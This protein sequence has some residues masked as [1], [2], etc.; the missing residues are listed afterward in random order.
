[1]KCI[2]CN[3]EFKQKNHLSIH[4][5]YHHEGNSIDKE[6]LLIK[7]T[8]S[9]SKDS[10][11]ENI[12]S[13]YKEGYNSSD[14]MEEYNYDFRNFFILLGMKRTNSESKK[15]KIYQ[16]KIKKTLLEKYGVDNPSKSKEIK[17]KR[18][19]T[20]IK[21][22]GYENNF[23]NSE[24]RN[25]AISNIDYEEAGKRLKESI[26][27]KYGVSNIMELE[28]V[29]KKSGESIKKAWSLKSHEEKLKETEYS[30]S[31]INYVSKLELRI[32]DILNKNSITYTANGFLY[33]YNFDIIFKNK[34]ILEIQGDFWH[35]N[36]L[37]YKENDILLKG[38]TVKKVWEKDKK[39]REKL[40]KNGYKIVY[41]WESDINQM[42]D[43]ELFNFLKK[44]W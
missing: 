22:F 23:C 40:E 2:I 25:K 30:R 35:G 29:R 10:E 9:I 38:L 33:N 13:R 16:E 19:Q 32:Q 8:T 3:K 24:I 12:I 1:M 34:T 26:F 21:N 20:F 41:L 27:S 4:I 17:E 36:P 31:F 44:I 15:T 42:S 18:K 39:K 28:W 43:D 14:F 6:I 5:N 37:L 11:I 7:S